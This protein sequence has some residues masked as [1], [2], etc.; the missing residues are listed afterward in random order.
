[1]N[2]K[3]KITCINPS[4]K[5]RQIVYFEN[6]IELPEPQK[7]EPNSN[8]FIFTKKNMIEYYNRIIQK[9]LIETKETSGPDH[10]HYKFIITWI[11]KIVESINTCGADPMAF[12][13]FLLECLMKWSWIK[14]MRAYQTETHALNKE[15]DQFIDFI[16]QGLQ[17][18]A[19]SLQLPVT[20]EGKIELKK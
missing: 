2:Q 16:A 8:E 7:L 4:C 6:I 15:Q 12:T 3:K 17:E 10:I 11:T 18:F 1:M 9:A 14:Q 19:H 5:R 13:I 20:N